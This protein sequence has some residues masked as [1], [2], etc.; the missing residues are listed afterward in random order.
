MSDPTA[1]LPPGLGEEAPESPPPAIRGDVLVDPG[2]PPSG[3]SAA[4]QSRRG[5]LA[6]ARRVARRLFGWPWLLILNLDR[7]R[8]LGLASEMA[9]WL[10]LALMPL[11]AVLGL[12]VAKLA[13]KNESAVAPLLDPMPGATREL[14]TR[15]LSRVSA[16]NGGAVAPFA[17]AVF[18]WFASGGVHAVF[19]S[20]ELETE[21][22]PRPWWKKR[23]LAIATC[24]V[25]SIGVAGL[26]LLGTGLDWVR[27][28]AGETVHDFRIGAS[29]ALDLFFRLLVGGV[30]LV[31]LHVGIYAVGVPSEARRRMPLWPG[32]L[33]AVALESALGFGYGYYLSRMGTQSAYQASLSIV[34]ITLMTL[35]LF[36][37]ALLAGAE[38]NQQLG[39]R[40]V[41][42]CSV[43]RAKVTVR[44]VT[45][46]MVACEG[47][48]AGRPSRRPRSRATRPLRSSVA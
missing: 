2:A 42:R 21:S 45:A 5:P 18:V 20:L 39:L 36:A 28:L 43:H 44:P 48:V 22:K 32:A 17:A 33:L 37:T 47:D 46:G 15:E 25:L 30:L 26:T 27:K 10:F 3:N 31:L 1:P 11:A 14:V 24:L 9:F 13:T 6:A 12:V 23:L 40:H 35:W 16:W 4:P 34:A 19:D 29:S 8:T 41:V 38:L 7:S